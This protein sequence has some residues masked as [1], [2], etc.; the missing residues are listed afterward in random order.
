VTDRLDLS[1]GE[2]PMRIRTYWLLLPVAAVLIAPFTQTA[3]Y[4]TPAAAKPAPTSTAGLP[5]RVPNDLRSGHVHLGSWIVS[6]QNAPGQGFH[7]VYTDA[8]SVEGY[9][10][11]GAWPDGT[12]L[13]KEI[14]G[15]SS[16]TLTTGHAS[17]A[18]DPKVWFVMVKDAKGL[19]KNSPLWGDGWLWALYKADAPTTNVAASYANDCQGCHTPAAATDHVFVQGYPTLRAHAHM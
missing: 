10:K 2:K 11:D 9:R 12:M 17:W 7:D 4:A 14:R 19:Y 6:D 1:C 3:G 15:I 8:K 16:D 13:V 18:A 5:L